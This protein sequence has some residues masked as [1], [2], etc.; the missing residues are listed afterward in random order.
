MN[1]FAQVGFLK[2]GNIPRLQ[3]YSNQVTRL[4]HPP[5]ARYQFCQLGAKFSKELF[6]ANF[7]ITWTLTTCWPTSNLVSNLTHLTVTAPASFADDILSNMEQW[8]ESLQSRVLGFVK[9]FRYPAHQVINNYSSSPNRLWVN[10]QWFRRAE[11]AINSEPM[12]V[13]GIT[14]LVKSIWLVK[15]IETKQFSLV[16][17]NSAAIVLVFKAGAF[18]Y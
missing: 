4:T 13:R 18:C 2:Y 9:G 14:V 1:L 17:C 10:S 7:M 6:T 12:R 11:W 5:T 3:L 15:N 16:K 8:Q